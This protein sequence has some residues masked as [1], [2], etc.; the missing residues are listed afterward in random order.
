MKHEK[1]VFGLP[2]KIK[3]YTHDEQ[4][5][6]L[7]QYRAGDISARNKLLESQYHYIIK[8]ASKNTYR[9]Y[10]MDDIVHDAIVGAIKAIDRW[11]PDR[12]SLASTIFYGVLQEVVERLSK[13]ETLVSMPARYLNYRAAIIMEDDP[14]KLKKI[15]RT[16]RLST[17]NRANV[18]EMLNHSS[19]DSYDE[20]TPNGINNTR[21]LVDRRIDFENDTCDKMGREQVRSIIAVMPE[22]KIRITKLYYG[23][24]CDP[25]T[26]EQIAK[27]M[28]TTRQ[29]INQHIKWV[30]RHLEANC[31][32]RELA[33]MV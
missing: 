7:K 25:H 2:K 9:R 18:K 5:E 31:K 11:N 17:K 13:A 29:N 15:M 24:G 30:T 12:G 19:L 6:L 3:Y 1:E 32:L 23:I 28:R 8:L 4:V 20:K 10:S 16:F 26:M 33:A 27:I 14:E 21:I 22:Q